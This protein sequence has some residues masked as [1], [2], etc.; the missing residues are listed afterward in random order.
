MKEEPKIGDY[1][2]LEQYGVFVVDK[3]SKFFCIKCWQR[4]Y[5]S[6]KSTDWYKFSTIE[7]AE[8]FIKQQKPI[9]HYL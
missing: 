5:P 9:Y 6:S 7:E 4:M 8:T 1:R 3:Y 2:I